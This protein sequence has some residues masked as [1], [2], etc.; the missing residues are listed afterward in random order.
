MPDGFE[1]IGLVIFSNPYSRFPRYMV[2]APV[3]AKGKT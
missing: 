1:A 2:A 3:G